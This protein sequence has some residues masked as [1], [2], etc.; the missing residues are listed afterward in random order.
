MCS[1]SSLFLLLSLLQNNL[2]ILKDLSN[3]Q[4]QRRMMDGFTESRRKIL[5]LKSNNRHNWLAYTIGNHLTG[6]HTKALSILDALTNTADMGQR[7]ANDIRPV[8]FEESEMHLYRAMLLEEAGK[9]PE[10]IAY[11]TD[12]QHEILDKLHGY[13]KRAQLH[14]KLGQLSEAETLYRQLVS[15]NPENYAYHLGLQKSLGLIDPQNLETKSFLNVT[16]TPEQSLKLFE[17]YK[18]EPFFTTK[19]M[20]KVSAVKR[21]PLNFTSGEIFK[22]LVGTYLKEKISRGIPSLFSDL[23]SLYN[24]SMKC[25][26]IGELIENY[27]VNLRTENKFESTDAKDSESPSSFMYAAYFAAQHYDHLSQTQ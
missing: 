12:K 21:I 11:L 17:L 18:T 27:L 22:G 2:Q 24:D 25:Q 9:L 8:M 26:I 3:L 1:S 19:E 23:E 6:N 4:I 5:Q 7:A 20:L 13:E 16:W 15:T 10:A 14:V